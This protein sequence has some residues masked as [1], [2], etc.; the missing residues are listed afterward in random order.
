MHK[1]IRFEMFGYRIKVSWVP[2]G[3]SGKSLELDILKRPRYW[4][5]SI[6][7]RY[8]GSFWILKGGH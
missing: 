5:L 3:S 7:R 6:G 2:A 4:F 1:V 8:D